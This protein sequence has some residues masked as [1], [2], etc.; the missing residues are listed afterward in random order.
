MEQRAWIDISQKSI[1]KCPTNTWKVPISL[2]S[3]QGNANQHH[4]ESFTSQLLSKDEWRQF[5]Q[6]CG[7]RG[8]PAHCVWKHDSVEPL[9]ETTGNFLKH[10]TGDAP[11]SPATLHLGTSPEEVECASQNGPALPCNCSGTANKQPACPRGWVGREKVPCL[12]IH[13]WTSLTLQKGGNP[14]IANTRARLEDTVPSDIGQARASKYC[15]ISL[16]VTWSNSQQ[17]VVER[18]WPDMAAGEGAEMRS[19]AK[20]AKFYLRGWVS[21]GGLMYVVVTIVIMAVLYPWNLFK[22]ILTC[23]CSEHTHTHRAINHVE[24]LDILFGLAVLLVSQYIRVYQ[25]IKSYALNIH[26]FICQ[27][28]PDK[29]VKRVIT[30]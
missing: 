2:T 11:C 10:L 28:Y 16:S 14:A 20:G 5:G 15:M 23:N 8:T 19:W 25:N 6:E 30:T 26:I 17:Q 12:Y 21:S 18:R 9:W 3:H 7:E 1:S 29:V 4:Q 22:R 24:V 13:V 27:R